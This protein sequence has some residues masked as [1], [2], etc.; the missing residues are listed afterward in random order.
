MKFL[1]KSLL[2]KLVGSFFLV[3][4]VTVLV[5]T[6]TT[7]VRGREGLKQSVFDRLGVA[8][9]LK[10]YQVKQWFQNRRSDVVLIAELSEVRDRVELLLKKK[11]EDPEYV[12]A[13][14]NL[15]ASLSNI[16]NT[17]KQIDRISVLS[18][19]GIIIF[20]TD[21]NNIGKYQ[22][23]GNTT[24]LFNISDQQDLIKPNFYTSTESGN[25]MI[26]YATSIVDRQ[27]NRLA[28]V[29]VDLNLKDIDVLIRERT[30]L[31]TSG[32]TYLVGNL[33][34]KSA[35]IS[36]GENASKE[37]FFDGIKSK[38]MDLA[39]KGSD[40]ISLSTNY[41]NVPVIGIYNWIS[42]LNLALIA[43]M[44]QEEAFA[45]ADRL[46]KEILLLGLSSVSYY[47]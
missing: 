17:K 31:G 8:N 6:I 28:Y 43:E 9:A 29:A 1:N 46:A 42:E 19:A 11:P 45:P 16:V 32:E 40:S 14:K 7:N 44:S 27:K 33:E 36:G 35:F 47:S 34:S 23:L 12:Q 39:L 15:D 26:T 10:E 18:S 25:P 24:T 37:Q 4:S 20:S 22:P 38:S 13:Y 2:V 3:S 5:V 21:K 41:K 30:G